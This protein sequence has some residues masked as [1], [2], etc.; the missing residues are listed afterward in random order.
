VSRTATRTYLEMRSPA[1]L[2]PAAPP[3]HAVRIE[4]VPRV[5][6]AFWRYLY[7][8]VGRAF[9]WVDRLSWTDD[10]IR[11]YFA[12]P[13]LQ[14]W[15]MAVGVVPAGYFELRAVD[16]GSVEIA[17]FG[18]LPDFVGQGLGK[19]MLTA[20]AERAWGR[21]ASR[22]WLHTSSL[23]HPSAL[24]NYLARGFTVFKT[25]MYELPDSG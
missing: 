15:V 23:D 5:P 17:Y 4:R 1:D 12:D 24:N 7:T 25:E 18:L 10:D 11:R 22:V 20:A 3:S 19:Y 14:L 8:E 6:P 9:H 21:R 16:D 13:A 2:R